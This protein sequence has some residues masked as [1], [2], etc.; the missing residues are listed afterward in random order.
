MRLRVTDKRI[1]TYLIAHRFLQG[2]NHAD[3]IEIEL[4][5][6]KNRVDYAG[7][8][9][10][11]VGISQKS[12]VANQIL[13]LEERDGSFLLTWEITQDFTSVPG[14]LKLELT[15]SDKEGS[16][17]VKYLGGPIQVGPTFTGNPVKP[18]G[19]GAFDQALAE[20]NGILEQTRQAVVHPPVIGENRHW[21]YWDFDQGAYADTGVSAI[22]GIATVNSKCP[23]GGNLILTAQDIPMTAGKSVEEAL[24]ERVV[25][26]EG[27]GLS[28]NDFTDEEKSKLAVLSVGSGGG[29]DKKTEFLPDGT[30]QETGEGYTTITQF[31]A[32]GR[33]QELVQGE[34]GQEISRKVTSFLPDGSIE[35]HFVE[36]NK[37]G[38]REGK[39]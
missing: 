31:L 33:I 19:L 34:A 28:S 29:G 3:V 15:G 37:I 6:G 7:L 1:D 16:V 11:M 8:Q 22:S 26:E 18:P 10:T 4:P 23:D 5:H 30:I 20:L 35:E 32:D 25:L 9:W 27:K 36:V 17:I 38:K 24:A 39:D 13:P 2:E 14:L 21:M 12:T